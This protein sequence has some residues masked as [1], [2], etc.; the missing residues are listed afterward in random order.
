[1]RDRCTYALLASSSGSPRSD[2]NQIEKD[3]REFWHEPKA[4]IARWNAEC[5]L[6]I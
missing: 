4:Q 6:G 3:R 2:H 5:P 1:M